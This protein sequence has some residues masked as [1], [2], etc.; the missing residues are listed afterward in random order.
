MNL[1][2]L[3]IKDADRD[4]VYP[5]DCFENN[6]DYTVNEPEVKPI[7]FWKHTKGATDLFVFDA[8]EFDHQHFNYE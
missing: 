4:S 2:Q 6:R 8:H 1:S 7:I 5:G 3:P